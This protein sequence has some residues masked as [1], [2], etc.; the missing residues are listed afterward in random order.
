MLLLLLW[1]HLVYYYEGH[2]INNPDLR[3][4]TSH[5]IRSLS[6]HDAETFRSEAGV[7]L[8]PALQR[9]SAL[10]LSED[11]I[12]SEWRSNKGYI[13]IMCRRLRDTVGL[14]DGAE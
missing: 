9:L 5:A 8:A 12:G 6:S 7:R 14:H 4:S 3:T 10:D 1:R 11:T 2:H 13:E